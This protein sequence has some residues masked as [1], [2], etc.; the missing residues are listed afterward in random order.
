MNNLIEWCEDLD[1][2][3]YME[4]WFQLATSS[5]VEVPSDDSA[6]RVYKAGLGEVTIGLNS[7]HS[8]GLA[9]NRM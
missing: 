7:T 2:D 5:N 6:I 3:K 8:D 9:S 1:Y 4:N